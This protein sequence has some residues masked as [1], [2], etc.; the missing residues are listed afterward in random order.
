MNL[1]KQLTQRLKASPN[2]R[3]T[4]YAGSTAVYAFSAFYGFAFAADESPE[5]IM[6]NLVNTILNIIRYV[7]VLAVI[8]GIVQ[9][10]ISFSSHDAS[11][12]VT[13]ILCVVGGLLVVFLK[14]LL[15][16]IGVTI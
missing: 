12:R 13:G 11:Q 7:G 14:G 5:V 10:G 9:L 3:K 8:F 2:A 15:A 16:A 4:L 1:L 6:G